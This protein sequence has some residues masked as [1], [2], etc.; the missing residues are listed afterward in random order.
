MYS[1]D[2]SQTSTAPSPDREP[3]RK[4]SPRPSDPLFAT[5]LSILRERVKKPVFDSW[6][7]RLSFVELDDD[8]IRIG[9]PNVFVKE[10]IEKDQSLRDK[11]SIALCEAYAMTKDVKIL[12][13][14]YSF[15]A[16]YLND[17]VWS[18]YR[19]K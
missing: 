1:G 11:L 19:G 7:A 3:E 10:W 15:T 5:V 12:P 13:D 18:D 6:F 9:T 16:V 2:A 4:G 17:L 8:V 14:A